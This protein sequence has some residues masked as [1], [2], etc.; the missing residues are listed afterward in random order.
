VTSP[1][2][3]PRP[4]WRFRLVAR[5]A[6]VAVRLVRWRIHV[7]GLEHV[8]RS[9]GAVV[10]WNHHGHVDF[11][12]AMWDVYRRLGRTCRFLAIR[13]L[14]SSPA[15][16]WIPRFVDAIPVERSS[17]AARARSLAAGVEAL[18][19]GHL[20]FIAPEAGISTS[21]ELRPFRPGAARMAQAAGVPLIPSVSWGSHR[22]TTTGHRFSP[23]R[24]Y[25]I[26]ICVRYGHPV[27]VG[28]ED[29]VVAVT[30]HLRTITAQMLHDVQ[31][32]YPDGAPA[33]AWWVPSRLGGGAPPPSP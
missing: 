9:G 29:D 30:E 18:R 26:P 11:V 28:P 31:Q 4:S 10:T 17:G 15:F 13:E 24:A 1:S 14:W 3:P 20:V 7:E 6:I 22:L 25:A 27:L 23:R 19:D 2:G 21:F 12:M 16:G 8:P 5:L 32:A 33:G